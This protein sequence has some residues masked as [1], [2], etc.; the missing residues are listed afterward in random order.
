MSSIVTV[1]ILVKVAVPQSW[2]DECTIFQVK[3]QSRAGAV[4]IFERL[5]GDKS[6]INY[7]IIDEVEII[8]TV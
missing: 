5:L 6:I 4:H 1:T 2:G 7:K 8:A 3:K